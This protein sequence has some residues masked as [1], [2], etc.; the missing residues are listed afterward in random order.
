MLILLSRTH[1]FLATSRPRRG[2]LRA[3]Q[4]KQLGRAWLRLGV[5]RHELSRSDDVTVVIAVR[6][7]C[8]YRLTNALGSIRAQTYPAGLIHVIVVDYGS[9]PASMHRTA[10]SCE[11]YDAKCIRID[12]AP[13]WSRSRGLNVGIRRA[14][15]K[16]LMTC[17]ADIIYSP[18]YIE[19]CIAVLR[20]APLSVV[21]AP[22]FD[23]PEDSKDLTERAA[24]HGGYFDLKRWK[25]QC[26][27][28]LGWAFHPSITITFTAFYQCVRG[29]DEFYEV[30]GAEDEDLMLRF[31]RLGLQP[32]VLDSGSFYLHQ[33]HPKFED[34]PGGKENNQIQRNGVYFRRMHS[35]MRN[36]RDWGQS[37]G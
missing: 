17:D 25:E 24:N 8:D 16:Y 32:K 30:W 5:L 3:L 29:Y 11:A 1:A 27:P 34:V 28:R 10:S 9:E 36:D 13:V 7:R 35:I 26:S 4:V 20:T 33:W 21:C 15:T 18:R 12:E 14:K 31:R 19:D 22:M 6:N 37:V 23:L 2:L